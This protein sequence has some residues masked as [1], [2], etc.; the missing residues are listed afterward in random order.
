VSAVAT[1]AQSLAAP[2]IH[3]VDTTPSTFEIETAEMYRWMLW[4]GL[5]MLGAAAFVAAMFATGKA[6]L[7]APAIVL[8][9]SDIFVLVWLCMSSDTNGLIG[10]APH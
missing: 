7:I 2:A 5:P 4:F 6:W 9:V 10:E 1:P 8:L 3:A